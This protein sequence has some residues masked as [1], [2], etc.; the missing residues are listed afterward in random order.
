MEQ[1]VAFAMLRSKKRT[2]RRCRDEILFLF[3]IFLFCFY[4]FCF[5]S[6]H[7]RQGKKATKMQGASKCERIKEKD[8]II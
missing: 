8:N 7:L 4:L 1:K 6:F 3:I 5:K 2:D